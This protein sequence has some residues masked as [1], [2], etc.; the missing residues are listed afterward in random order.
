ML[1]QEREFTAWGLSRVAIR[2]IIVFFIIVE[3]LAIVALVKIVMS[4]QELREADKK[5]LVEAERNGAAKIEQLKNEQIQSIE[6]VARISMHQSEL[7]AEI[8]R[9]TKLIEK[10]KKR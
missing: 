9:M 1:Q 5:Q 4:Q 3:L 10:L 8:Q 7:E 6:E 2:N